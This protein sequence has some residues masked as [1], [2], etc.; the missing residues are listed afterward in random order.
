MREYSMPALAEIPASA[1]LADVVG[2][3]RGRA[4]PG[5]HAAPQGRRRRLAGRHRRASSAD[6]VR[7]LAKGLIAAGIAPGDRVA[8]MSHTRYE[9]TLLDYAL[10]SVGAVVVPIY[11]TSS[12]EQAEWILS[13]SAAR[14]VIVETEAF[15]QMITAARDRLP[16]LEHLWRMLRGPGQADRRQLRRQRRDRR[17]AGHRRHAPP[18]WPRSSTPRAP[19]A[20]PRG[21]SSPTRTCSASSA[22]RSWGRWP[23]STPSSSRPRCCSCRS[24]TSSRGSSRS[25]AW[26]PASSSATATTWG[27]CCP[28]WR[29]SSRPSCSRCRGCSRRSTTAPRARRWRTARARSS[30]APR[31][32]AVAYSEAL[33]SAGRPALRLRAEHAVFDRLV[34]KQAPGRPRRPAPTWRSP[35]ARRSR[36]GSGTSSAASASPSS[37]DTG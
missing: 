26:R 30:P 34:Y 31:A 12:A 7:A 19:P 21:A 18:T 3:P 25:A 6:E 13:D 33:D 14:A 1:N 2:A 29:R 15:E 36:R 32:T 17:R 28:S 11:E 8:I 24:R 9:W 27:T 10:W 20:G 5:C 23:A 22:T 37:R 4:A 35:A 16:A